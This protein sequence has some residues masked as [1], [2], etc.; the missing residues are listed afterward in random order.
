MLVY[1]I[2]VPPNQAA[3][4]ENT[5]LEL[6]AG[7]LFLTGKM[8]KLGDIRNFARDRPVGI[9]WDQVARYIVFN[10]A[11]EYEERNAEFCEHEHQSKS[12]NP[13]E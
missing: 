9:A 10:S 4:I 1:A 7:R 13:T 5:K 11:K 12:S 3:L 8:T 2:G 6:L